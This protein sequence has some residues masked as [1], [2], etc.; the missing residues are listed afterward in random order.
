MTSLNLTESAL[1]DIV[2]AVVYN[3]GVKSMLYYIIKEYAVCCRSMQYTI[4]YN[5][6][7]YNML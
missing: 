3:I 6:G 2:Y 1:Y 4:F 7:V 5:K